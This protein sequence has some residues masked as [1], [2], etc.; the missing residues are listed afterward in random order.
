ML[1]VIE[2]D[3]DYQDQP[4]LEK[5]NFHLSAGGLLHV[6]GS[7]GVGKT[8]LLKLIAGLY[9]PSK[10]NI[11]F[12]GQKIENNLAA[13]QKKLCFLGH[14]T[15]I[16][17]YLTLRENCLFDLHYQGLDK[18]P[19]ELAAMFQLESYVDTACG[20]LSAGQK[21]QVGLLRLWMSEAKLWVLDEP[22]VA[23]D[24]A[25]LSLVMDKIESHRRV[26]GIVLLSSHQPLPLN[27]DHYQE[28]F[29]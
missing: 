21:R 11:Q 14:K 1:D 19:A 20:L 7:N 10:G 18:N 22:F 25:S 16:H 13:Y 6:R 4:L 12:E 9:T 29:L 24:E 28:L 15:G 23:L 8:S 17:P 2:L 27:K 5:V 26:G 3:F